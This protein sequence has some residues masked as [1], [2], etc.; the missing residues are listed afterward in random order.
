MEVDPKLLKIVALAKDGIGGE[1]TAAI[2]V[3]KRICEREGLDFD[4]VMADTSDAVKEYMLDAGYRNKIEEIIISQVCWRFAITNEHPK[5]QYNKKAKTFFYTCTLARHI[6]TMN[7]AEVYLKAFRKERNKFM[8]DLA[9]AFVQKHRLFSTLEHDE[10][11]ERQELDI[12]GE[13]RRSA[14]RSNMDD[15]TINKQIGKGGK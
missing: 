1:K 3:L 8:Q 5:L 10:D 14:L 15:V 9:E 11:V 6:E 2:K 7:A 13:I 12:E 4:E